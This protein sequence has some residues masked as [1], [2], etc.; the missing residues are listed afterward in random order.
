MSSADSTPTL[1]K[2]CANQ[3][4]IEQLRKYCRTTQDTKN[5][6]V[7]VMN[8]ILHV[9]VDD[10]HKLFFCALPKAGVTSWKTM[11][12][13]LASSVRNIK[14]YP[15]SKKNLIKY[16]ITTLNGAYTSRN[17]TQKYKNYH[18][19]LAVRHPFTRLVSAYKD[20]IADDVDNRN[21]KTY[22][23]MVDAYRSNDTNALP[24]VHAMK[25]TW[26]EFARFVSSMK[27]NEGNR[28]WMKYNELCLPCV[29]NYDTIA[30]LETQEHDVH[31][32]M[33][34]VQAEDTL[35]L[36]HRHSS[37]GNGSKTTLQ[38]IQEL[39]NDIIESL[40]DHFK[41]DMAMFGYDL[42]NEVN[43]VCGYGIPTRNGEVSTN[44]ENVTFYKHSRTAGHNGEMQSDCC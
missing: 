37:V 15:H 26:E 40:K 33:S 39:P 31:E 27:A 4:R 16:G 12:M 32:F 21:S 6:D 20:K 28:H 44:N 19:I 17:F 2:V 42:D 25:P 23:H 13:E 14:I 41:E 8:N 11:L 43:P 9:F 10:K 29:I 3:F 38:Y 5:D 35:S 34:R 24:P 18:K 7:I 36:K 1:L 22:M 30:K